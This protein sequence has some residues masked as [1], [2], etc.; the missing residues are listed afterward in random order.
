LIVNSENIE[1][2]YELISIL[3]YAYYLNDLGVL[4]KTISGN[5]TECFYFFSPNHEINTEQRSWYNTRKCKTP[6]LKIHRNKLDLTN[7]LVPPL[8]EYWSKKIPKKLKCLFDKE[9]VI[10]CNRH[11]TE[12]GKRPINYF[13]LDTLRKMFELLQDKYQVIYINIE[14]RPEL[15]DNAPPESFGDF[16]LLK[17]YPKVI[18]IH[19]LHKQ[20]DKLSYNTFQLML[21]CLCSKFITSNGG[22][23]ILSSYFGGENIILS[24]YGNPQAQEIGENVN[25]YYRWYNIFGGQ[26]CIHVENESKLLNRIEDMWI[27]KNPIVNILVRTSSRPNAF[28]RCIKSILNQTYKNINIFVSID[29]SEDYTIKYPVYPVFVSKKNNIEPIKNNPNYGIVFPYNLYL[30]E[31]QDKVKEGFIFYLD[32]DNKFIDNKAIETIVDEYKKGSE[33]IIW[34]FKCGN[35][36]IPSENWGKVPVVCDIDGNSFAFDSKYKELAQWEGYKRG[37]FRVID[38]LYKKIKNKKFIDKIFTSAQMGQNN[39]G[40]INDISP[41]LWFRTKTNQY[42][43]GNPELIKDKIEQNEFIQIQENEVPKHLINK[44]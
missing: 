18:N 36:I 34:K 8:K 41:N 23:A 26:R 39:S 33:L 16:D 12:W 42:W 37:D 15:Y 19:E 28:D 38:K 4:E 2:G 43:C 14:G 10:I 29:N 25:S 31:L 22:Y 20:F 9:I 32:D 27:E 24:K 30:N 3:P 1:F 17:E 5:D 13:N 7:F 6:N 21:F 35:Q 44:I 40:N 11:N